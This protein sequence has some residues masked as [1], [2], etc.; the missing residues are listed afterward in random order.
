MKFAFM[1][2]EPPQRN[3]LKVAIIGAGPAGLAA[4]GYLACQGYEV[5]V[6]DK[7][8]YP[9][10]LMI[11]AIPPWRIPR[12]RVLLGVKELE[13][14]YGV[15]FHNRVKV[16]YGEHVHEEGDDLVEKKIDLVEILGTHDLVL[17]TTGIWS[18]KKPNIPGVNSKGITTALELLYPFRLHELGLAPRPALQG[19]KMIVVGGGF[20]AIDAA[21]QGLKLGMEVAIL[22]R[23]TVK[24]APAGLFEVERVKKEGADFIELVSPLEIVV[25]NGV[26]KG[27]KVQKMQLGPPD[28]T[29]R[30]KPIPVPGSEHVI[31][32]DIVVFATGESPTPPLAKSEEVLSKL[33]IKLD[34]SG[35]IVVNRIGQ[36]GNPRIFA[37]GD[38]VNGPSKVGPAIKSGLY[39]AKYLHN[40][41][42][43]NM[44][45]PAATPAR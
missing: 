39:T 16:F 38:V 27:V 40:W 21:E 33:G 29:G 24:E 35:A 19:K 32:A 30:P 20:S 7:Q 10:G 12:E 2:K 41:A 6:Y 9:G 28:E 25:E 43:I 13:E 42:L 5:E 23:R 3:G 26:A 15:R 14:K 22:Y 36:T 31:E 34:K 18:S 17:I 37:A 45:K 4:S 8:P 44:S 11:F 1:C